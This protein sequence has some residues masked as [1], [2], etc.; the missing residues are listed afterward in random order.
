MFQAMLT[1]STN[2]TTLCPSHNSCCK[3]IISFLCP[4]IRQVGMRDKLSLETDQKWTNST[5]QISLYK[6]VVQ[7]TKAFDDKNISFYRLTIIRQ[8]CMRDHATQAEFWNWPKVDKQWQ[9]G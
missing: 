9:S 3:K 8:V 2:H 7:V 6:L 4:T 5:N 1:N